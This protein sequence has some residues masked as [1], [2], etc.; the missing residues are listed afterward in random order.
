MVSV[1]MISP[2]FPFPAK[3][4][5]PEGAGAP[6]LLPSSCGTAGERG[7]GDKS[8]G[9]HPPEAKPKGRAGSA[10]RIRADPARS[11]G[12]AHAKEGRGDRFSPCRGEGAAPPFS[13]RQRISA[14]P[15]GSC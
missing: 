5:L 2:D 1:I 12:Q 13:S 7:Q 3:R 14:A 8:E 4:F 10:M 6:L 11:A 9:D 15:A